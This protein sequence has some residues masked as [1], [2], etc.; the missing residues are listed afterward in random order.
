MIKAVNKTVSGCLKLFNGNLWEN[1]SLKPLQ[2]LFIYIINSDVIGWA[3]LP[4]SR[5]IGRNFL[6]YQ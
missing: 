1:D 3:F 2:N 5:P 6:K 4:T